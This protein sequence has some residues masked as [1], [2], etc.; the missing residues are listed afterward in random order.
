MFQQNELD[1]EAIKQLT[2]ADIEAFFLKYFFDSPNRPIRRISAH[3]TSQRLQPEAL[4]ALLPS[5]RALDVVVDQEQ[6]G[7]FAQSKPALD[8][9]KEFSAKFLESQGKS[10]DVIATYVASLDQLGAPAVPEGVQ[11]IEDVEAFRAAA[12]RAPHSYPMAEVRSS[13]CGDASLC[14]DP[15]S[16]SHS[17]RTC[18]RSFEGLSPYT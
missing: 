7:Q 2:K 1:A 11:L 8:T 16:R 4:A 17:T 3:L 10:P 5:L 14:A 18:S 12:E 15:S 6:F 9:L 13:R